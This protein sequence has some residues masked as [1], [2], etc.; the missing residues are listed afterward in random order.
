MSAALKKGV[1]SGTL[2]K[3]KASYKLSPEAKKPAPKKKKV[4]K[5]K[6]APKKKTAPKKKVSAYI[7]GCYL[8][9]LFLCFLANFMC[10]ILRELEHQATAT[11]KTTKK[12]SE[13]GH[14]MPKGITIKYL[15]QELN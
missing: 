5:K 3:V 11:K 9:F 12:V 15:T 4:V 7:L 2:I 1:E 13:S 6:A 8:W 10:K 14:S